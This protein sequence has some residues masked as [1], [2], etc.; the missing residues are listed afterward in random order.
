MHDTRRVMAFFVPFQ[1]TDIVFV[2][3]SL[4]IRKVLEYGKVAFE[5]AE[6]DDTFTLIGH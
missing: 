3:S 1:F 4:G 6:A 2:T 5:D